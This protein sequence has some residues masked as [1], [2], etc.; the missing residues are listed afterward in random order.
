MREPADQR[1]HADEARAIAVLDR[2]V[3]DGDAETRLPRA[4]RPAQ[5]RA[6]ALAHDFGPKIGGEHLQ[7]HHALE[8]E[9]EV[10]NRQEKPELCLPHRPR[11]PRHPRVGL[12]PRSSRR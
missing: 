4:T 7:A 12:G 3:G 9:A 10:L 8:G 2:A 6:P 5:H 11:H 1:V